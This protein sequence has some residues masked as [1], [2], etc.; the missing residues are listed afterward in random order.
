MT[1]HRAKSLSSRDNVKVALPLLN[2]GLHASS[3]K[4]TTRYN[5]VYNR[6]CW[7]V[8]FKNHDR[9]YDLMFNL[10]RDK[11]AKWRTYDGL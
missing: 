9:P 5:A 11:K 6:N 7:V 1:P 3:A 4:I 2:L 8:Y 10:S